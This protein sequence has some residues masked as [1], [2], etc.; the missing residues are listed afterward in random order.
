LTVYKLTEKSDGKF[1]LIREQ[2]IWVRPYNA[3]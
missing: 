1:S 3:R 2:A